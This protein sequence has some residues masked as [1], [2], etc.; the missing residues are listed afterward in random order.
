[1]ARPNNVISLPLILLLGCDSDLESRCRSIA[2]RSRVLVRSA[3]VP[4]Q[5]A[6]VSAWAPLVIVVP[7][8]VYEGAPWGFEVLAEKVGASLLMLDPEPLAPIVLEYRMMEAL[9]FATRLRARSRAKSAAAGAQ[10]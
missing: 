3:P 7:A 5:R 1:M 9:L 8:Q 4:V 2:A 6:E 10:R